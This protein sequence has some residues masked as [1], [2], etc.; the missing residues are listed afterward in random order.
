MK[1]LADAIGRALAGGPKRPHPGAAPGE[2]D[3][4][5]LLG[6]FTVA[7]EAVAG[8]V[9][10]VADEEAAQAFLDK[11]YAGKVVVHSADGPDEAALVAAD[12][13]V[14]R[15]DLLLADTG[16]VLRTYADRAASRISLVP[17]TSVF[18]AAADGVVP[19][20][21]EAL[22]TIAERHR[23]GRAYSV[24]ITGPSRTADI[25][26]ELVIPAH[27]PRELIVVVIGN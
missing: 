19:G 27:G 11:E 22:E 16:T 18:L 8:R 17:E 25:E 5:D 23:E 13:G 3:G 12:V 14:Y 6:R 20:Y 4:G 24:L 7:L 1:R 26:K 15:A 2:T 21:P 10:R 9:I